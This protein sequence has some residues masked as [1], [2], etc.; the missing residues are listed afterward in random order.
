MLTLRN[1]A[2]FCPTEVVGLTSCKTVT[3]AC[4][5][6]WAVSPVTVRPVWNV[7]CAVNDSPITLWMTRCCSSTIAVTNVPDRNWAYC[8]DA[9][10][11]LSNASTPTA[12]HSAFGL[13]PTRTPP[14]VCGF[15]VA[16]VTS[17]SASVRRSGLP[18]RRNW[19]FMSALI[20]S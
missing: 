16:F 2:R 6:C 15:A 10:S 14:T 5:V 1:R 19:S 4:E 3:S 8:T 12:A 20:R 18:S 13:I 11:T 7:C 9:A 17:P